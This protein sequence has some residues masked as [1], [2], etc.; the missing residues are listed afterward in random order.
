MTDCLF[1][2]IGSKEIGAETIYEDGENI[3]FLDI[4]PRA[5]GHA[6]VIPKAHRETILD[7]AEEELKTLF[8][9]VKKTVELLSR[10]L[11]PDGF[12]I[13]I[14]HGKA[15]GQEVSHLHVHIIPRYLNDKGS[16]IHSVVDNKS[17]GTVQET[18]ARIRKETNK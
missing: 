4:H 17:G 6:M 5:P 9:A 12:T 15:S 8:S 16:S 1:C 2:R 11:K 18:A 3:S 10:A 13:G 7:M 14:N